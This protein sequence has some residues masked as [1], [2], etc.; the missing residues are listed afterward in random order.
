MAELYTVHDRQKPLRARQH[1]ITHVF[2][3]V[4]QVMGL[5]ALALPQQPLRRNQSRGSGTLKLASGLTRLRAHPTHC[6]T[7][8]QTETVSFRRRPPIDA[9]RQA[10]AMA[11]I[12]QTETGMQS[13]RDSELLA[14]I[15]SNCFPAEVYQWQT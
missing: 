6:Q 1:N 11:D 15:A 9:F 14:Q 3:H 2:P 13:D 12:S 4:Q 5:T 10:A 7:R 8:S